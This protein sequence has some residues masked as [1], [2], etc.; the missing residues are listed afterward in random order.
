M[1]PTR[2]PESPLPPGCWILPLLATSVAMLTF[3]AIVV[4][5]IVVAAF[6]ESRLG[7]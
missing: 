1:E 7:P 5:A 6:G 2:Q 3:I 4:V